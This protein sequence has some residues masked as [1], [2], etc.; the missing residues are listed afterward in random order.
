MLARSH[1]QVSSS[2][3]AAAPVAVVT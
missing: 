2:A 3:P 1:N